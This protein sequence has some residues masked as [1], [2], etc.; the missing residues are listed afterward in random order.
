MG[1]ERKKEFRWEGREGG[2]K[3]GQ[4]PADACNTEYPQST[5]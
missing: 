4:N 1:T 3:D 5:Q 2:K